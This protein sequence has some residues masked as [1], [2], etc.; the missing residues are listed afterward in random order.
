ML[1]T[2]TKID[3][4]SLYAG[5]EAPIH[6][7]DCGKKCAPHN[8]GGK[9]FCCDTCQA[10][11][12]V[13]DTEWEYLKVSTDLWHEFRGD[14]CDGITQDDA[15]KEKERLGEDLPENML[16]VACLGPDKCQRDYR[17]LTCRQFPFFPYIDSQGKFLGLSYYWDFE[18]TCWVIS[19]MHVVEED[20]RRQFIETFEHIF[21]AMP[22]EH[23]AYK[24][25]SEVM[26][27]TFNE[28]GRAIPLL[29]R[30]GNTYKI[31]THNERMRRIDVDSLQKFGPYKV[32]AELPFPDEV[33]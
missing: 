13:Y 22:E 14:E 26:R 21:A 31:S 15:T 25:H 23:E 12:T 19:N 27:D 33:Q 29:H 7:F 32:A 1:Q 2:K 24:V 5:F 3:Y 28:Q 10:V 11:P 6:E 20:Y 8:P 18:D 16:L 9:P 4:E 30:N 17:G